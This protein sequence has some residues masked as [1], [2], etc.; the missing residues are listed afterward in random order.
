MASLCQA[1][2]ILGGLLPGVSVRCYELGRGVSRI[3][4]LSLDPK[5]PDSGGPLESLRWGLVA[6]VWAFIGI[7]HLFVFVTHKVTKLFLLSPELGDPGSDSG[8]PE[9]GDPGNSSLRACFLMV[10]VG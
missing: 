7:T 3:E 10:N 9:P 8:T 2:W 5:T 4:F 1:R 6:L